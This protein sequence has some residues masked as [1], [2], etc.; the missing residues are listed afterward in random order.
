MKKF[1]IEL[2]SPEQNLIETDIE[3]M[4]VKYSEKSGWI[5]FLYKESGTEM[6]YL[7]K[8]SVKRVIEPNS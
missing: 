3:K 7:S 8:W 1:S 6:F 2:S 5:L 4:V